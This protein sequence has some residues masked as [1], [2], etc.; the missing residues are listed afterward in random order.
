MNFRKIIDWSG[1]SFIDYGAKKSKFNSGEFIEL[2]EIYKDIEPAISPEEPEKT[3]LA[4]RLMNDGK[5]VMITDYITPFRLG[6]EYS[7]YNE[8]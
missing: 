7:A 5:I 4:L 8:V 6:G 1:I 3:K 2:L